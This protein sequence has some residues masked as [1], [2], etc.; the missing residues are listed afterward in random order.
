MALQQ[1]N[2]AHDPSEESLNHRVESQP[3]NNPP[4]Q[5]N[6][7]EAPIAE[8][9]IPER[10]DQW[11]DDY[12]EDQNNMG[13]ATDLMEG[14]Q[15]E[16]VQRNAIFYDYD[17]VLADLQPTSEMKDPTLKY[18]QMLKVDIFET[19]KGWLILQSN[20]VLGLFK[21]IDRRGTYLATTRMLKAFMIRVLQPR[22][23]TEA[24]ISSITTFFK[25]VN[26]KGVVVVDYC[27]LYK[28]FFAYANL[29][30]LI[31]GQPQTQYFQQFRALSSSAKSLG[32][33]FDM[34][35]VKNIVKHE[36]IEIDEVKFYGI[37]KRET[38]VDR[39]QN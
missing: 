16:T 3:N 20:T 6:E 19:I 39:I 5:A 13:G 30:R 23:C 31:P 2:L 34:K 27:T 18:A 38:K 25:Q 26:D 7:A 22:E 8:D 15:R 14:G 29:K 35:D 33:I 32:T 4:T 12:E 37:V 17:R 11:E 28:F 1:P 10:S 21:Q 36:P 24:M 9:I